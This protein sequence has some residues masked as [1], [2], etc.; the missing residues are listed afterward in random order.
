[1]AKLRSKTPSKAA[2]AKEA[3]EWTMRIAI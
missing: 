1:L 2:A 3:E